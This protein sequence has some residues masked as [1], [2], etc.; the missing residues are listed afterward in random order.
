MTFDI[1]YSPKS[2][3]DIVGQSAQIKI[4]KDKI[5]KHRSSRSRKALLVYGPPGSGKTSSIHA[6]ARELDLELV[7][8]NASDVRNTEG[9]EQKVLPAL[10]QQSLFGKG[11]MILLDEIDGLSGNADR[12]GLPTIIKFIEESAYPII[13]TANDIYDQ[14][15][16]SLKKSCVLIEFKALSVLDTVSRLRHVCGSEGIKYDEDA[17]TNLARSSKG[18]LR[19]ALNDLQNLASLGKHIVKTD[20]EQNSERERE[21]SI[22]NSLLKIFKTTDPM[23]ALRAFDGV[24]E[25]IDKIFLWLDENLSKEYSLPGDLANAYECMSLAD[26]YFGRIRRWQYY[27]YYVY[28]YDLLSVGIALSKEKKNAE[29]VQY[30]PTSRILKIWMANQKHARKKAIAAKLSV[31]MHC[32]AHKMMQHMHFIKSIAKN[33]SKEFTDVLAEQYMLEKEEIEWLRK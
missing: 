17:L 2:C 15:F 25:D 24:D 27:R 1:K 4:I 11:K 19:S 29:F 16:N 31:R 26:L 12:G 30:S 23:I 6:L 5:E 20:V 10:R 32:S 28:I 14:K 21:E 7:E 8:V 9:L 13:L 33:S 22:M 3:K 18:D